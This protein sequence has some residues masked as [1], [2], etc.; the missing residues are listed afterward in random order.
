MNNNPL[1]P[2]PKA[3]RIAIL[4]STG[5]IDREAREFAAVARVATVVGVGGVVGAQMQR[6]RAHPHHQKSA[7]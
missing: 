2:T 3:R 5:A 6:Q 4:G 7:S 1:S